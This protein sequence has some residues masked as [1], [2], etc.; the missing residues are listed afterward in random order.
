TLDEWDAM[1]Y[2][3][4][5]SHSVKVYR[6]NSLGAVNQNSG[7][8]SFTVG[9]LAQKVGITLGSLESIMQINAV[10]SLRQQLINAGWDYPEDRSAK[11]D[12][13]WKLVSSKEIPAL[14]ELYTKTNNGKNKLKFIENPSLNTPGRAD[15][16]IIQIN[17]S[18]NKNLLEYAFTIGHEMTH[19]FTDLHFRDKFY[20]IYTDR[21]GRV[22]REN[23]YGFFKEVIGLGWEINH[24]STRYSGLNDVQAVRK[25]YPQIDVRAIKKV[26]PYLNLLQQAWQ[27]SYNSK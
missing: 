14:N 5:Q 8:G 2:L 15:I 9:E 12:D 18:K 26:Q 16:D 20:E 17:M 27:K 21:D 3:L 25:Y 22:M 13:W 4:S 1:N 23:T 10:L 7:G 6:T 19:S 11:F 24:G